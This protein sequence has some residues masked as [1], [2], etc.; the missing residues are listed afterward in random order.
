[1]SII[2]PR[3]NDFH[4]ISFTQEEVDFAIPFLDEDIP[5]YVDPFLLW[6]SPSQQD[7]ALHTL[8]TN[9]FNHLGYLVNKGNE[10]EAINILVNLS[11]C[12]EVGLGNSKTKKGKRIGEKLAISML[13]TFKEFPQIYRSGFTHFEEIQLLVDNISKDRISDIACN[14]IISFLIDFTIE[15]S[16]KYE[17]PIEKVT[18]E[19]VYDSKQ[20]KFEEENTVLPIHPN[21]KRPIV[22]VPKRWLRYIPWINP[23]DYFKH[24]LTNPDINNGKINRVKLLNFNRH[25]YDLVK[26]YTEVKERKS[27]DCKNDPLFTQIPII[28]AKRK[29]TTI[30]ALPS[31]KTDNADKKYEDN[32]CQ[33]MASLLYPHL[34]F[35]QEQSR[36]DSNVLIRDLIFYNNRSF[37]FLKDIYDDYGSKQIVFELKNVHEI[38]REHVY[39]LNRYL[40]DN[41][42]RFGVIV[43]R[44]VPQRNIFKNTIDLW[45]GQRR[46]ILIFDDNDIKAMVQVFG[47]KQRYPIEYLKKKY[48]EF[49]RACP[50]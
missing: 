36:T 22:F 3:L 29:L 32:I 1:M 37:D 41:L 15:Q 24:C 10:K 28:S 49:T 38:T 44:N 34:D 39:Q 47:S 5:L 43:T 9:S 6:K 14:F 11:E 13:K 25:N 18:L 23:D 40:N 19:R 26:T 45:S 8:I 16:K 48:V 31:G 2:R 46:C 7:N 27:K 12:N 21:T 20:Y 35:A 30:L 42:G 33:L 50:S 17:I 4:N